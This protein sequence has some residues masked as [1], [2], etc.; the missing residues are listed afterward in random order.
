MKLFK[1]KSNRSIPK[2]ANLIFGFDHPK[3]ARNISGKMAMNWAQAKKKYPN[4]SPFADNDRDGVQNIFDCRPF[5]RRRQALQ[6]P[7]K[8]KPA[9]QIFPEHWKRIQENKCPICLKE[10]KE[11]EFTSEL[12]KKEYSISGMCQECQDSVFG[13]RKKK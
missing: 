11:P 6:K 8:D 3:L 7:S 12:S 9:W 10:I 13:K 2:T 1:L 4:L 5:D